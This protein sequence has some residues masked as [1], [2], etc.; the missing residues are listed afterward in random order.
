MWCRRQNARRQKH[1]YHL[2][3]QHW[4]LTWWGFSVTMKNISIFFLLRLKARLFYRSAGCLPRLYCLESL[5]WSLTFIRLESSCGK[6]TLLLCSLTMATLMKKLWSS[7]KRFVLTFFKIHFKVKLMNWLCRVRIPSMS[8]PG[9]RSVETVE[10][11]GGRRAGSGCWSRSSPDS[12]FQ[13]SF[14]LT[15]SLEPG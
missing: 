6:S 1:T 13:R 10:K 3:I 2:Q 9:S 5:P 8:V 15:E 14:P 11:A 12:D 7:S 4:H